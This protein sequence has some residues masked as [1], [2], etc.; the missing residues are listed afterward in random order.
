MIIFED[1]ERKINDWVRQFNVE[2][3]DEIGEGDA[4]LLRN[5]VA[6]L[7]TDQYQSGFLAGRSRGRREVRAKTKKKIRTRKGSA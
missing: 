7:M 3:G 5:V 6:G 2:S 1:W 4:R